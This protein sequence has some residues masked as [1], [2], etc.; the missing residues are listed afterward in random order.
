MYSQHEPVDNKYVVV[1]VL[2][3]SVSLVFLIGANPTGFTILAANEFYFSE[4]G[5]GE[6]GTLVEFDISGLDVPIEVEYRYLYIADFNGK[7]ARINVTVDGEVLHTVRFTEPYM[8]PESE[9]INDL[10]RYTKRKFQIL[11]TGEKLTFTYTNGNDK[12]S[13]GGIII[14]GSGD[15]SINEPDLVESDINVE[16]NDV[17]NE[18]EESDDSDFDDS[19][20]VAGEVYPVASENESD[21]ENEKGF[22]EQFIDAILGIFGL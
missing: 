7:S 11:E 20:V 8:R 14:S 4:S 10:T 6:S 18:I 2:L 17:E 12:I 9:Q 3:L 15:F 13:V 22:I 5:A 19:N 16:I 21:V 1:M